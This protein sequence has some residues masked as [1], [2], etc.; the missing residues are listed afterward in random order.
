MCAEI[1]II[2]LNI[3]S[4]WDK[5]SVHIKI[6]TYVKLPVK[7]NIVSQ[8]TGIQHFIPQKVSSY[9]GKITLSLRSAIT[10]WFFN[11]YAH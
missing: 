4:M 9:L 2:N 8:N 5:E 6:Y 1:H 11:A 10:F 7:T 3:S